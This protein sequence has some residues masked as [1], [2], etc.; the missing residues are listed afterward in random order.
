MKIIKLSS[1]DCGGFK[2]PKGHLDTQMFPECDGTEC[3]RNIVKKTVEKRKNKNKKKNKKASHSSG[4]CKTS[5]HSYPVE[6]E[7]GKKGIWERWMSKDLDDAAF[8]RSM[9]DLVQMGF[10]AISQDPSTRQGIIRALKS[11]KEKGY[12]S[13]AEAISAALGMSRKADEVMYGESSRCSCEIVKAKGKKKD[14]DPNPWAVCN[15]TV[16][17][18]KDPE[19]F[20][21]CV[22]KVK[23]QQAFNLKRFTLAQ[24]TIDDQD[25]HQRFSFG[26]TPEEIIKERVTKQTPGGYSMHIKNQNEWSVI[27]KAVN[28]GIDSHLE[29]F[30]RS[31][32]DNKTGNC[33]IHPEEMTTFLRRLAESSDEEAW[34]LRTDILSTLGIEEI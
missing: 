14:W 3:D 24:E 33:L 1:N 32:F 10:H 34:I 19:K 6:S 13:A 16:D 30:S 11:V 26:E 5:L 20:E 4:F 7:G 23:K 18:D 29:G 28:Q 31:T 22:K 25:S 21:R 2:P 12:R 17:K 27:A 8:V 9:L 15:T